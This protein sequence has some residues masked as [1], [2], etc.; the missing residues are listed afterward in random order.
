VTVVDDGTIDRRGS[1][2]IDDEGTP[3]KRTVLIED[4]ILRGYMQDR[5]NA[6]LMGMARP[7]TAGASPMPTCPMPRMTNTYH[8]GRRQ[9]PGGDPLGSVKKGLYAVNFGGGQVDITNRQVRLLL[10]RGL[11]DRRRQDRPRRSRARR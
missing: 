5:Q 7:A 3:T 10:H 6:R 8:A 2:T 9:G 11:P 4:G 1:L